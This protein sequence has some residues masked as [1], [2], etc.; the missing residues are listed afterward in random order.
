MFLFKA[1]IIDH[2]EY[3]ISTIILLG[4]CFY[5]YPFI[6]LVYI[7]IPV[8]SILFFSGFKIK[9]LDFLGRMSYSIYLIHP[10]IGGS[11]INILSHSVNSSFGKILVISSG[12]II[13]TVSSYI[14]YLM[15]EKPSKKLS[16]SVTYKN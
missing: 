3:Y 6:S 7:I 14:I 5:K 1:K 4:F 15:V 10:L 8:I 13:T 2:Y 9:G 11:F 12:L 16:S